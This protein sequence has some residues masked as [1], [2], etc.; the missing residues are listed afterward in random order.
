MTFVE[1]TYDDSREQ[2]PR[3]VH[4]DGRREKF[5]PHVQRSRRERTPLGLTFKRSCYGSP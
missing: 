3:A 4:N 1:R 2:R 5:R